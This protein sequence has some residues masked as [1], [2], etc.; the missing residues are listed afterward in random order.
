MCRFLPLSA[1]SVDAASRRLLMQ[2]MFAFVR[3]DSHPFV[4][5]DTSPGCSALLQ[6]QIRDPLV[7][8]AALLAVVPHVLQRLALQRLALRVL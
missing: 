5:S 1:P 6:G 3:K 2:R 4:N 8:A 7:F